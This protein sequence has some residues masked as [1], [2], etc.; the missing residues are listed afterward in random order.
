LNILIHGDTNIFVEQNARRHFDINLTSPAAAIALGLMYLKTER[1]DI[2][3]ML[4]IPDTVL[5]LNRIQPSFLLLRTIARSLIM[6]D[7]ITPTS[8][9]LAT[10]IPQPIA[11][12]IEVRFSEGK[13]IDDALELAY[14]N[15]MAACCFA[16]ALKYAG[17]ARQEAYLMIVS[18]FD[19][20]SRLV[21]AN[22]ECNH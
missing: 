11:S 16:I 5:A 19:L 9:W 20:Y 2:A 15:I 21:F 13:Q 4:P 6:W 18:Y 8:Q 17:T 12:A 7:S 22:G 1:Q 3:D 10:Q 14:Y